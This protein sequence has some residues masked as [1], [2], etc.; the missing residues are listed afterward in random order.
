LAYC[1]IDLNELNTAKGYAIEALK[2]DPCLT[3]A[4]RCLGII[5][6]LGNEH[7]GNRAESVRHFSTSM[8]YAGNN[9]YTLRSVACIQALEGNYKDA[10]KLM[11]LA[12]QSGPNCPLAWR[13]LGIM[14]YLYTT[15]KENSTVYLQKAFDLSNELDVESIRLKG[16]I[17]MEL[18]KHSEARVC[19]QYAMKVHPGDAITIASLAMSLSALGF[20]AP[21]VGGPLWV[22]YDVRFEQLTSLN[23]LI[24]S[25]DPEELFQA[26]TTVGLERIIR[27]RVKEKRKTDA[28]RFAW[29]LNKD[30]SYSNNTPKIN[31]E[32]NIEEEIATEG[33]DANVEVLYWYGMFHMKKNSAKS[34]SKAKVMFT[35]AV[36]RRDCSPH[37]MAVYMLGWIAELQCDYNL[38]EKY[39]CYS[40]QIEPMDP[41]NFLRLYTQ[42]NDTLSFVTGLTKTSEQISLRKKKM[43]KRKQKTIR[44]PSNN[45]FGISESRLVMNSKRKDEIDE[46]EENKAIRKYGAIPNVA[47]MRKRLIL[48]ERVVNLSK[49]K[50]KQLQKSLN[51]VS[52][53]G[54][55]VYIDPFWLDRLL[56]SFSQCDDW[57]WLMKS[58]KSIRNRKIED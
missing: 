3:S 56:Y 9:P 23:Q 35:R 20:V 1:N 29:M 34:M 53:P 11:T 28:D 21:R 19:F 17:L 37:P 8:K 43:V 52:P 24:T 4:H 42:V 50:R 47:E 25:E 31:E 32:D 57:G 2:I 13:A 5:S 55:L 49:L 41:L 6:W 18:G 22:D 40:L 14:T 51:G 39:Y 45:Q 16:Q 48:H 33:E 10:L 54:K 27:K 46:D 26:A 7:E 12:V 38:A 30:S 36:Q 15:N 44:I 58:S